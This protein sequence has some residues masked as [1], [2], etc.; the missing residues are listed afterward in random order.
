MVLWYLKL[1]ASR[2]QHIILEEYVKNIPHIIKEN[3]KD[4]NMYPVGLGNTGILTDDA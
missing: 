3:P 1:K 4:H 2:K